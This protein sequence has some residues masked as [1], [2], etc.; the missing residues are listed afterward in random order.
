MIKKSLTIC[1]WVNSNMVVQY[2]ICIWTVLILFDKRE[3]SRIQRIT[4]YFFT[5]Y[6]PPFDSEDAKVIRIGGHAK[7]GV[8][9][10]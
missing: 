3:I 1:L 10:F 7:K 6:I 8:A 2:S 4:I 9:S 5:F